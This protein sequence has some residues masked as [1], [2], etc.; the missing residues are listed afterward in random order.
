MMGLRT[1]K[2]TRYWLLAILLITVFVQFSIF[3]FPKQRSK[4]VP[5]NQLE[6]FLDFLE[7]K[8]DDDF[9]VG[10]E[11]RRDRD[12]RSIERSNAVEFEEQTSYGDSDGVHVE[13]GGNKPSDM[14]HPAVGEA[15]RGQQFDKSDSLT[16]GN[17]ETRELENRNPPQSQELGD[18][19]DSEDEEEED[20]EKEEDG[21]EED[22]ESHP[23]GRMMDSLSKVNVD[24]IKQRAAERRQHYSRTWVSES[25][26]SHNLLPSSVIDGVKY[27][28][29]FV[30]H[31]RGGSSILGSLIDAHPHIVVAT[32]YELFR[33]WQERPDYHQNQSV[34]YTSLYLRSK[35]VA[36]SYIKNQARGY[37]LYIDHAYMGKY[38]QS[39][40]VIG[41]KEAGSATSLFQTSR[42]NWMHSYE[43]MKSTVKVPIK[44]MQIIRNPFDNI[45]T[46]VIFFQ[47][48]SD[49]RKELVN[50]GGQM[51]NPELVDFRIRAY[52]RNIHAVYTMQQDPKIML[53]IHQIHL[54]DLVRD[55]M[56]SMKGICKFLGVTCYDWYLRTCKEHTF[57][58]ISKTRN[59]VT[60]T[61]AQIAK[62]QEEIDKIPWLRRYNFTSL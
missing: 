28:L 5:K 62:V 26:V 41:E 12:L 1:L 55:P 42:G 19:D 39:I 46:M 51:D 20:G 61:A 58:D 17:S 31:G 25:L 15:G 2:D 59:K 24:L 22:G 45:A 13:P 10:V 38:D 32:D 6:S 16:H 54:A 37:S 27:F 18:D 48:G 50:N 29:F 14:S 43:Q 8:K 33:K 47:G 11:V 30:G 34:L 56:E 44:V 21:E 7:E 60:W 23:V 49:K 40:S 53:D 35:I 3:M 36:H 52:F 4:L 57:S 9:V